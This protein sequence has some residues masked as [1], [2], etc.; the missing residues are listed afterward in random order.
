MQKVLLKISI[1]TRGLGFDKIL[2]FEIVVNT[3]ELY[4]LSFANLII[5]AV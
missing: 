1:F 4:F 2:Y 5:V 3:I